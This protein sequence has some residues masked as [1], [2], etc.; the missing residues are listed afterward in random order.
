MKKKKMDNISLCS[1]VYLECLLYEYANDGKSLNQVYEQIQNELRREPSQKFRT[2]AHTFGGINSSEIPRGKTLLS[3]LCS[4]L[5]HE[6]VYWQKARGENEEDV[7]SAEQVEEEVSERLLVVDYDPGCAGRAWFALCQPECLYTT[8]ALRTYELAVSLPRKLGVSLDDILDGKSDLPE[9]FADEFKQHMW[10]RNAGSTRSWKM[11]PLSFSFTSLVL[12][13]RFPLVSLQDKDNRK[14]SLLYYPEFRDVKRWQDERLFQLN[15]PSAAAAAAAAAD[16]PTKIILLRR[17]ASIAK[18]EEDLDISFSAQACVDEMLIRI[19]KEGVGSN[20]ERCAIRY[21]CKLAARA[22]SDIR[23]SGDDRYERMI[24]FGSE[25]LLDAVY[26][27][28]CDKGRNRIT[29]SQPQRQSQRSMTEEIYTEFVYAQERSRRGERGLKPC[30]E[31]LDDTKETI[32][33]YAVF[34]WHSMRNPEDCPSISL[35]QHDCDEG[36]D[37]PSVWSLIA[38]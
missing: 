30:F 1:M 26:F 2:L 14:F 5:C 6:T 28:F 10:A 35:I 31:G 38:A 18:T 24:Y 20:L 32:A 34:A 17:F 13:P 19:W 15:G 29:F 16:L 37:N 22:D 9:D 4:S 36:M 8:D 33:L 25:W 21:A 12:R 11:L 7:L 27:S 3:L 23:L